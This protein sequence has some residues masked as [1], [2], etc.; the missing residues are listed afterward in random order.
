MLV[1]PITTL[2]QDAVPIGDDIEPVG[3]LVQMSRQE[4]KKK[5]KKKNSP[6]EPKIPTVEMNPKDPTRRAEQEGEDCGHAF[7]RNGCAVCIDG[8]CVEKHLQ[9]GSFEEEERERIMPSLVAFDH[10]SVTQENP[11]KFSILIHRDDGQSQTRVTWCERKDP[12]PY[13][14]SFL[15]DFIKDLNFRRITLKCENE[16]SVK[17]PNNRRVS[18]W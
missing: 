1:S 7:Y 4:T 3:N 6:V 2:N 8:R 13:L 14:I 18:S 5:K 10:V 9:V 11:D 17:E 16:P 15:V 12:I